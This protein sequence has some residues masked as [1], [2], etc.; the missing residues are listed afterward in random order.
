MTL[1]CVDG[2]RGVLIFSDFVTFS[3]SLYLVTELF[4]ER[5]GSGGGIVLFRGILAKL[6]MNVY[7]SFAFF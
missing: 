5:R 7:S 1:I 4:L 6:R 2:M 3:M